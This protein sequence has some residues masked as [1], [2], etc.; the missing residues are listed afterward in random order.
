LEFI[1]ATLEPGALTASIGDRKIWQVAAGQ[2]PKGVVN[3]K[4]TLQ[5][6]TNRIQFTY[7]GHVARPSATDR[8][9]LGFQL[10]NLRLSQ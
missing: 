8:R 7:S 3:L 10:A 6:G 5:P 2:I 4:L 9:L 1:A